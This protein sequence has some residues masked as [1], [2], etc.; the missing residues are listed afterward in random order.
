MMR[1]ASAAI[2]WRMR[3]SLVL[4]RRLFMMQAHLEELLRDGGSASVAAVDVSS[5]VPPPG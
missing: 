4:L 5:P 3:T 2:R 1:A